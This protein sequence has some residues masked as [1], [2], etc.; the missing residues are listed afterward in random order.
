MVRGP[1]STGLL[2][3]QG[4]VTPLPFTLATPIHQYQPGQSM[5]GY[6]T[7]LEQVLAVSGPLPGFQPITPTQERESDYGAGV[8]GNGTS[9]EGIPPIEEETEGSEDQENAIKEDGN[10]SDANAETSGGEGGDKR[11]H[12]NSKKDDEDPDK[13]IFMAFMNDVGAILH[14]LSD[15]A[16]GQSSAISYTEKYQKRE[17]FKIAL[18]TTQLARSERARWRDTLVTRATIAE[19]RVAILVQ[20]PCGSVQHWAATL[21]SMEAWATDVDERLAATIYAC[22]DSKAP[23]VIVFEASMRKSPETRTSGR[24]M[25]EYIAWDARNPMSTKDPR[26]EIEDF[27]SKEFFIAGVETALNEANYQTMKDEVDILPT[28]YLM[29]PHAMSHVVMDHIPKQCKDS[30]WARRL[31]TEFTLATRFEG[32]NGTFG[33]STSM[34]ASAD[35]LA[36]NIFAFLEQEPAMGPSTRVAGL[37]PASKDPN[38]DTPTTAAATAAAAAA[39][40]K[41]AAEKKAKKEKEAAARLDKPSVCCGKKGEAGDHAPWKC[42]NACK[43][44]KDSACMRTWNP[45]NVCIKVMPAEPT[46]ETLLGPASKPLPTKVL[47]RGIDIWKESRG[48]GRPSTSAAVVSTQTVAPGASA[49]SAIQAPSRLTFV[50]PFCSMAELAKITAW[51]EEQLVAAIAQLPPLTDGAYWA[52]LDGGSNCAIWGLDELPP[53]ARDVSTVLETISGVGPEAATSNGRFVLDATVAGSGT[54]VSPVFTAEWMHAPGVGRLILPESG[55]LKALRAMIVK[56]TLPGYEGEW[57]EFA[58]PGAPNVK[59]TIWATNGLYFIKVTVHVGSMSVVETMAAGA[60]MLQA[61][62]RPQGLLPPDRRLMPAGMSP[63]TPSSSVYAQT[64]QTP[65]DQFAAGETYDEWVQAAREAGIGELHGLR[66]PDVQVAIFSGHNSLSGRFVKQFITDVAVE[67]LDARS[68]PFI[69][70]TDPDTGID[71]KQ[72]MS[73]EQL[74]SIIDRRERGLGPRAGE[75]EVPNHPDPFGRPRTLG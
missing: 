16:V 56:S 61:F 32:G 25:L 70:F 35:N 11:R 19:P 23:L 64:P 22:L 52:Q 1:S 24:L 12:P 44:C 48:A 62:D 5:P 72:Q 58:V 63:P 75:S 26:K 57:I 47:Q 6:R 3:Q 43:D 33:V 2:G 34:M 59:I 29:R 30:E 51:P 45:G 39:A 38:E 10:E 21:A 46:K 36:S 67:H 40:D 74:K 15:H 17:P 60:P 13:K 20:I 55:L 54:A 31:R 41:K 65:Q 7:N 9:G 18:P 73:E 69:L 49:S 8:F 28:W 37:G 68:R 42:P 4:L 71:G 66:V 27:E 14:K 53:A 50:N